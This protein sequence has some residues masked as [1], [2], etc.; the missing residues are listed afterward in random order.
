VVYDTV[1]LHFLRLQRQAELS[2]SA[3]H[4]AEAARYRKLEAKLAAR[5][6]QV[7]CV[8][9]Q[10]AAAIRGLAPGART[11]IVPTIHAL[12]PDPAGYEDRQ[13]LLFVGNFRHRPNADAVIFFA[14]QVQ[15]RLQGLLPDVALSVAG[16]DAPPEVLALGAPALQLLGFVPDLDPLL[17]GRRVFVCPL[18]F[19]AGMKGKV[20]QALAAGLPVV[21]TSI[22]AEGIGLVDGEHAL[23]ADDPAQFAAR[24]AEVYRDPELWRRLSENGRRLVAERFSPEIAARQIL[25]A[26][27]AL[28][29][30]I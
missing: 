15:P 20:G 5:C 6:D 1:D 17:Q 22:G 21:T 11:A 18:R 27:R 12:A 19:G 9:E 28:G 2:R 30:E 29:V 7:W 26:V 24:V 4:A 14:S 25:D 3:A 13:G 10:E 16:S 23:I 8:S